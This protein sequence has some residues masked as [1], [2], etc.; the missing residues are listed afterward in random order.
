MAEEHFKSSP[1]YAKLPAGT[2]VKFGKVGDTVE[3]MKPLINCKS[4][5]AT[6]LTGST[7]DSTVLI[8]KNKQGVSD[9]PEGPEKSIG[10]VDDPENEDFIEFLNA[11]QNRDTVQFYFAL[12]NKRTATMIL[13]LAGWEL[14]D[15]VAPAT[16]VIQITVKAKQ[17]NLSWGIDKGENSDPNPK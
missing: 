5:G 8:E 4:L 17:N 13:S 14:N 12:P 9:L 10:F 11:A 6:G 15:I 16:E 2:I 7:V 3:Q 1:E